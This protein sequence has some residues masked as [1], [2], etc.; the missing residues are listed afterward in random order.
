[1][2]ALL[3]ALAA[4]AC[5]GEVA[6]FPRWIERCHTFYVDA[7]SN[8]GVQVQKL[9]RPHNYPGARVLPFMDTAFGDAASRRRPSSV[10]GTCAVGFEPNE[11]HHKWL[12]CLERD[13]MRDGM[14][15]HFF[16]AGVWTENGKLV[17]QGNHGRDAVGFH[18]MANQSTQPA[19]H[20]QPGRVLSFVDVLARLP[21][22]VALMKMDIEG[23]E[24]QVL[25]HMI[26][27]GFLCADKVGHVLLE[28]HFRQECKILG[29][30]VRD[31]VRRLQQEAASRGCRPS[32]LQYLDDET[33]ADERNQTVDV[34]RLACNSVP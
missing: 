6:D 9:F 3:L 29:C 10:T 26:R 5:L 8:R 24:W 22:K 15:A 14:W 4:A 27:N 30:G 7:G 16:R 23:A 13:L 31:L 19:P 25:P 28:T 20:S 32:R 21:G 17:F 11:R 1:M 12:S 33:Y 18:A 34:A 2:R